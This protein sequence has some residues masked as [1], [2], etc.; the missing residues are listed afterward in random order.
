M[1]MDYRTKSGLDQEEPRGLV[2]Q[3]LLIVLSRGRGRTSYQ[4]SAVK[5]PRDVFPKS[6]S[7][8][9]LGGSSADFDIDFKVYLVYR[10]PLYNINF[11]H[12]PDTDNLPL[13]PFFQATHHWR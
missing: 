12:L 6:S 5:G 13:G 2:G 4:S 7:T 10:F 9:L 3:A 1:C 11:R 8:R